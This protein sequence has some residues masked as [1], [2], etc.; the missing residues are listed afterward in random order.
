MGF[1][2]AKRRTSNS[3]IATCPETP[4]SSSEF[5]EVPN[6]P[7]Q[8]FGEKQC[9]RLLKKWCW[10]SDLTVEDSLI[11]RFA[12]FYNYDLE[13]AK[14]A[15]EQ[16]Q[17]NHL[18]R[19]QMRGEVVKQVEKCALFPL[20]GLKSK[21]EGSEVCYFRP[22][23]FSPQTTD[24]SLLIKNLCYCL[25]DLS[26]TEEQCRQGVTFLA[27]MKSF[28]TKLYDEEFWLE[29]LDVLQGNVIPVNISLFIVLN[30]PTWFGRIWRQMKTHMSAD[31]LKKV[32]LIETEDLPDYFPQGYESYLPDDMKGWRKTSEI[33]EDY[34]DRRVFIDKQASRKK[35]SRFGDSLE[36]RLLEVP[37]EA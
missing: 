11:M 9:F 18:L 5:L 37:L 33:V 21:M 28:S 23:R 10:E 1:K 7:G 25:N 26:S 12:H 15:L 27:N 13:A 29:L 31:F 36:L 4:T 20:Q 24:S 6:T 14:L 19:L 30:P 17:D 2:L 35:K 8:T 3:S 34:I 16:N 22:S 32:R